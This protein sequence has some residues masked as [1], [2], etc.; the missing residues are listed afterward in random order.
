MASVVP[1]SPTGGTSETAAWEQSIPQELRWWEQPDGGASYLGGF[2][3]S[4]SGGDPNALVSSP[5]V[6]NPSDFF[7]GYTQ[8]K[9]NVADPAPGVAYVPPQP[10]PQPAQTLQSILSSVN[11]QNWAQDLFRVR[12]QLRAIGYDIN[13][14]ADGT[15][16][17]RLHRLTGPNGQYDGSSW[18]YDPFTDFGWYV[19][20]SAPAAPRPAATPPAQSG[21]GFPAQGQTFS[22]PATQQWEQLVRQLVEQMT[23]PQPTWTDAQ[24]DLMQT[25]SLDPLERQRTAA[26][27]QQAQRLAQRNIQPGSGIFDEAMA[28]IDRQFNQ[29]RTQTQAGFA[30]QA[31]GREDQLF[32]NNETR[33]LNAANLFKQIPQ[34]ADSRLQLAAN[35]LIPSNPAQLLSLQSQFQ[36][37]AAQQSLIQQQQSQQF[38]AMLAQM[39]SGILT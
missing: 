37:Q 5:T 27:Q 32:A 7:A 17:G 31:I 8:Q 36:G 14:A 38:W 29:M 30:T 18:Q 4:A 39:L 33:A 28:S 6:S 9:A 25:Q 3:T 16:R 13:I 20:P 34:Y 35:T 26:K 24:M 15:A 12:D 23:V 19:P 2:I 21:S 11:K 22:D 1:R 10:A